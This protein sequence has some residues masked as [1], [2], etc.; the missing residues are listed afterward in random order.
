M[1]GQAALIL[2]LRAASAEGCDA[3]M[4]D[5]RCDAGG[6]KILNFLFLKVGH[7]ADC[8]GPCI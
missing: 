3:R 1:G 8:Y 2:L 6:K 5:G 7:G 4:H